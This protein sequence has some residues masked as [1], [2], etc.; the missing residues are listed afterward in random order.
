MLEIALYAVVCLLM[1]RLASQE[2][3]SVPLWSLL[4]V[5]VCVASLLIPLVFLRV[6]IAAVVSFAV[7]FTYKLVRN[8]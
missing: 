6:L 1:G 2:R 7:M 5:G 3:M 8:A 4:T